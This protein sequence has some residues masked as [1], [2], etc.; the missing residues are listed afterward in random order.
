MNKVLS[1]GLSY[2]DVVV[3]TA[4]MSIAIIPL[5]SLIGNYKT[6]IQKEER[7][8]NLSSFADEVL[9]TVVSKS[10]KE[11]FSASTALGMDDGEGGTNWRSLDDVDDY[12]SLEINISEYFGLKCSVFVS[13]ANVPTNSDTISDAGKYNCTEFKNVNVCIYDADS[14]STAGLLYNLKAI[15][16]FGESID[17]DEVITEALF[18]DGNN[19]YA[20]LAA[21]SHFSSDNDEFQI[22]LS[23]W[24]EEPSDTTQERILMDNPGLYHITLQNNKLWFKTKNTDTQ[25][26]VK[27]QLSNQIQYNRWNKLELYKTVTDI[28]SNVFGTCGD[29]GEYHEGGL[30]ITMSDTLESDDKLYL[31]GSPNF[32]GQSVE[33]YMK[34]FTFFRY[35]VYWFPPS[36]SSKNLRNELVKSNHFDESKRFTPE[37]LVF[38]PQN[39]SAKPGYFQNNYE[40]RN[41]NNLV[42]GGSG[43]VLTMSKIDNTSMPDAIKI[44]KND[45]NYS[46]SIVGGS[47]NATLLGTFSNPSDNKG[48]QARTLETIDTTSTNFEKYLMLFGLTD[49]QGGQ[50][51]YVK[52]YWTSAPDP[53]N[54]L[55][56]MEQAVFQ[57][58]SHRFKGVVKIADLS[59]TDP[60][61]IYLTSQGIVVD[62]EDSGNNIF[63]QSNEV[64]STEM[65]IVQNPYITDFTIGDANEDG[66]NDILFVQSIGGRPTLH[67]AINPGFALDT[68]SLEADFESDFI[69]DCVNCLVGNLD[70]EDYELELLHVD[71]DHYP[72]ILAVPSRKNN[73]LNELQIAFWTTYNS[74]VGDFAIPVNLI[75]TN[76]TFPY[77]DMVNGT[78]LVYGGQ[79][80][81][82]ETNANLTRIKV[83]M[84]SDGSP[85]LNLYEWEGDG[86]SGEIISTSS[87][88]T[89][90]PSTPNQFDLATF[91]FDESPMLTFGTKY[92]FFISE[93][94]R[95]YVDTN[96]VYSGGNATYCAEVDEGCEFY[97]MDGG[98]DMNFEIRVTPSGPDVQVQSYLKESESETDIFFP[99]DYSADYVKDNGDTANFFINHFDEKIM[100]PFI[101]DANGDLLDDVLISYSYGSEKVNKNWTS[102]STWTFEVSDTAIQKGFIIKNSGGTMMAV[103]SS[104]MDTSAWSGG[105]PV[106]IEEI[107]I[108]GQENLLVNSDFEEGSFNLHPTNSMTFAN[109]NALDGWETTSPDNTI[110]IWSNGFGGTPSFSGDYFMEINAHRAAMLYQSIGVLPG[111]IGT[112]QVSHR[113]RWGTDVMHIKIG[114]TLENMITQQMASTGTTAWEVYSGTYVVPNG[115]SDII[116][117]FEAMDVGSVGNFI[118]NV[119][120]KNQTEKLVNKYF[121]KQ[122][123]TGYRKVGDTYEKENDD[124]NIRYVSNF[125]PP[126]MIASFELNNDSDKGNAISTSPNVSSF[127][128]FV[129]TGASVSYQGAEWKKLPEFPKILFVEQ[130]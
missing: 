46:I 41:E 106:Y 83:A 36:D 103:D 57:D 21:S 77:D 74:G 68:V 24:L 19:D 20:E 11:R 85:F 115:V 113:G 55:T 108:E 70:D 110:E 34:D 98:V 126:F 69:T 67:W 95:M 51:K 30:N 80:F 121:I 123:N 1:R 4:I 114:Q 7:L 22:L 9:Q 56:H 78:R 90:I 14:L 29:M 47:G 105:I 76:Y 127:N 25:L 53:E 99:E 39:P 91:V 54:Y 89:D 102:D 2:V 32:S 94:Q 50:G 101:L 87:L 125:D 88:G 48:V 43:E 104:T 35:P 73:Y 81:T 12:D 44:D 97:E 84:W 79:T 26:S 82:A 93:S 63:R 49:A 86:M 61:I 31:G 120:F 18:F 52:Y 122:E 62:I 128:E 5:S 124:E 112:W 119:I 17:E 129:Y 3:A 13:Y 92:M 59:G 27:Q 66:K 117:G 107:F 65:V 111:D 116:I 8:Y 37:Q 10:F 96:S 40:P 109:E 58:A 38:N 15:R 23:I 16:A 45:F 71:S 72:D 33:G 75:T 100:P 64:L 42:L 130:E 60:D 28:G 6:L 118:D